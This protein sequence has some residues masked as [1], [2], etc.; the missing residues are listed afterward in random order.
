MSVVCIFILNSWFITVS[1]V[2]WIIACLH[3]TCTYTY[4]ES[5][6]VC[7]SFVY[8]YFP[9][10]HPKWW[11]YYNDIARLCRVCDGLSL[12]CTSYAHIL[13]MNQRLS[14]HHLYM[15]TFLEDTRCWFFYIYIHIC[16]FAQQNKFSMNILWYLNTLYISHCTN[17]YTNINIYVMDELGTSKRQSRKLLFN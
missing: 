2:W 14:A 6:L 4:D 11:N 7:T 3:I 12:V 1:C 8:A 5:M 16:H 17:Y 13:M 15:L 10:R 9:W